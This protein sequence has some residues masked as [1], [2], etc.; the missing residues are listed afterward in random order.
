MVSNRLRLRPY[1]FA[2]PWFCV[3]VPSRASRGGRVQQAAGGLLRASFCPAVLS[4]GPRP[5]RPAGTRGRARVPFG[6]P[7]PGEP[8]STPPPTGPYR[9]SIKPGGNGPGGQSRPGLAGRRPGIFS[10]A[11]TRGLRASA[12]KAGPVP[13]PERP[14]RIRWARGARCPPA[15]TGGQPRGPSRPRAGQHP[16]VAASRNGGLCHPRPARAG[17]RRGP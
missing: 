8:S 11:P 16:A 5:G 14:G 10:A 15:V 17:R 13:R 12:A 6:S 2:A 3:I 7:G 4:G 9:T 1:S